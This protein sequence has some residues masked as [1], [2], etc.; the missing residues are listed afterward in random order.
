MH[1]VNQ[2]RRQI[3]QFIC[4]STPAAFLEAWVFLVVVLAGLGAV[5]F[6]MGAP[7]TND[8]AWDTA[9]YL[10]GAWRSDLTEKHG[11]N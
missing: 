6:F 8:R 3:H 10:E 11:S 7:V 5:F 4:A 9:L 2:Y 1:L